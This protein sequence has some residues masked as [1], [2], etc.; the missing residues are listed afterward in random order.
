MA[1]LFVVRFVFWVTAKPYI[2]DR[3]RGYDDVIAVTL[4]VNGG[5][6]G[7]AERRSA[8]RLCEEVFL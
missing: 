8:Y 7:L 1:V 4:I 2:A 5:D 3:G 6:M